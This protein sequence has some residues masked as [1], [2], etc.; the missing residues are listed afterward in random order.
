MRMTLK[1]K[2]PHILALRTVK[3]IK[4][5]ET[6][7]W[8]V[9]LASICSMRRKKFPWAPTINRGPS[10]P[11]KR[12]LRKTPIL[13]NWV[14]SDRCLV[15]PNK[16]PRALYS[17][18]APRII[19][20][21]YEIANVD[22]NGRYATTERAFRDH[23]TLL[24][25]CMG[26]SQREIAEGHACS[27]REVLRAM[28]AAIENL[29]DLPAYILWAS[30]TDFSRCVIPPS[31]RDVSLEKRSAF[32][33]NIQRNPFSANK[34]LLDQFISSPSYLSYLLYSS[35][36]RMRLTKGCRIYRTSEAL[37]EST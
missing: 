22:M 16:W 15:S 30:G 7:N 13:S 10:E 1:G 17:A 9:L 18:F 31:P 20:S 12:W 28:Y 19:P 36:K 35:P 24:L 32:V 4:Q 14:D 34:G 3:T 26:L 5:T 33:T 11:V 8:T 2:S 6:D 27:E 23:L 37:D 25:Y 29:H 21:P